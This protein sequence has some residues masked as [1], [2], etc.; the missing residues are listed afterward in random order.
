MCFFGLIEAADGCSAENVVMAVENEMSKFRLRQDLLEQDNSFIAICTDG[1]SVMTGNKSGVAARFR[2][3]YGGHVTAFHCLAHRLELAVDDALKSVTATN[4]FQAFVTTLYS[5]YS[6]SP[7][8]QR[9][10]GAIAAE[11]EIELLRITA[12]FGVRWVA[13]SY[14]A[15]R[16]MWRNYPA[17]YKHFVTASLDATRSTME[18]TKFQGLAKKLGTVSFLQDLALMKDVLTELSGLSLKLQAR[19]CNILKSFTAVD[20]TVA[21]L[22]AFKSAGGGKTLKKLSRTCTVPATLSF[23]GVSLSQG[24]PGI[25]PGQFLTA[26]I[27]NLNRRTADRPAVVQDLHMLREDNWPPRTNDAFAIFGEESVSRLARQFGLSTRAAV[28]AFRNYKLE[29]GKPELELKR[30][31]TAAELNASG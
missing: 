4:H 15:V 17:L 8:N 7:K 13:S 16:A 25:N 19:D 2:D 20:A 14:R 9:E 1:A 5:L 31:F 22:N 27:D 3:K 18:R 12:I 21:V 29:G 30:L 6:Q 11:T 28:E 10:L 24:K 26:V 23:K